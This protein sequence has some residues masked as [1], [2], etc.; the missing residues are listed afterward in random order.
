M[1][2]YDFATELPDDEFYIFVEPWYSNGESTIVI[3]KRG[4]IDTPSKFDNRYKNMRD[5]INHFA[6]IHWATRLTHSQFQDYK[7]MMHDFF[8]KVRE[9]N[10]HDPH[11]PK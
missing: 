6:T 11:S 4:I 10:G 7:K 9:E 8:N 2:E 3:S 1:S 5:K